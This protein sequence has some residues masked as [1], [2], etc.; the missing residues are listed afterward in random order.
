MEEPR[1]MLYFC[2]ENGAMSR[3]ITENLKLIYLSLRFLSTILTQQIFTRR[4]AEKMAQ[5]MSFTH[6]RRAYREEKKKSAREQTDWK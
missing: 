2:G 5:N 3:T 1:Q 4:K 6:H